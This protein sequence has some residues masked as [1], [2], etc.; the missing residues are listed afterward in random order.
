MG[1]QENIDQALKEAIRERSENKRNALRLLLTAIKV[2]EKDIKRRLNDTE[3]Q[4]VISSQIKQRK[5]SYDQYVKGGR[6]DLAFKEEE[7]IVIL[8]SFL[9]E[10]LSREA[11]ERVIDESIAETGAV[12]PKEMG[13][14]M[15]ILMPKIAGRADG[16]LVNE[17]VKSKLGPS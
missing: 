7:E 17:L 8:Q 1:L 12:S 3:I 14:V 10:A 5:D 2:K 16:K 13:K 6:Q 15:K 9:P 11:L 4:Q